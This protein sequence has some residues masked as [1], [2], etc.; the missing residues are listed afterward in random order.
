M[1]PDLFLKTMKSLA[2]EINENKIKIDY[3]IKCKFENYGPKNLSN[4]F[5]ETV[6]KSS[7]IFEKFQP[8]VLIILGD[9]YEF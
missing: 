4:V 3:R 2:K 8:D 7:K 6:K 9:R 5:S 1:H